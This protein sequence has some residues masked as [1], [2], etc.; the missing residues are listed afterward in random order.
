VHKIVLCVKGKV[1]T[2]VFA[3]IWSVVI[4]KVESVGSNAVSGAHGGNR[5]RITHRTKCGTRL[6]WL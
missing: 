4:N 5:T 6:I 3:V 2:D 1:I